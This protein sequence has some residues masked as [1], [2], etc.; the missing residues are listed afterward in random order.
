LISS[1]GIL[2]VGFFLGVRHATDADRV[3][4]VST[5]VGRE[6]GLRHAGM[7]GAAW[8]SGHTLTVVAVGGAIV[9]FGIVMPPRL[10]LSM[11]FAI[12]AMPVLLGALS[13]RAVVRGDG[14]H[15]GDGGTNRLGRAALCELSARPAVDDWCDQP[16]AGPHR[17]VPDRVL[18]W[19]VRPAAAVDA[20]LMPARL[21]RP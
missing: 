8:G 19:P 5:I 14:T 7:I 13:L 1:L 10:G 20:K 12:G 3:V 17:D 4:A 16:G 11:D 9:L 15:A 21:E 6:P 2:A 18:A